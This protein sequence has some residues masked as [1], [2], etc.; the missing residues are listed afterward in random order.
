[1]YKLNFSATAN[2]FFFFFR[3]RFGNRS[4]QRSN[5]ILSNLE[6]DSANR[7]G[8]ISLRD[9][10]EN[11]SEEYVFKRFS[12]D[13]ARRSNL[14]INS[15]ISVN[16]MTSTYG[17]KKRRAPQPPQRKEQLEISP[18]CVNYLIVNDNHT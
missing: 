9:E 8:D 15:C 10:N 16:S 18:V 4:S 6:E 1:M 7:S 3:R 12:Q 2:N 13:A 5:E 17:R 11:V 14:S